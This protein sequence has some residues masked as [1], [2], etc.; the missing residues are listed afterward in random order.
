MDFLVIFKKKISQNF[1]NRFPQNFQN[2]FPQ[3]FQNG[4]PQELE[5]AAR[6]AAISSICKNSSRGEVVV[7]T[8]KNVNVFTA[9]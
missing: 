7:V 2:V 6:R 1:Q 5:K 8:L 9:E 3:S 4:F